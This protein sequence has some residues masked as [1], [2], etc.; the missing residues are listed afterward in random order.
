VQVLKNLGGITA[1]AEQVLK[2]RLAQLDENP[3]LKGDRVRRIHITVRD[4]LPDVP[5]AG[6]S[7]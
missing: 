5:G 6:R 3:R 7:S 4:H 1:I 2:Q